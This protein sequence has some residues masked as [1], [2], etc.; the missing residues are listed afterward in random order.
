MTTTNLRT[1]SM[2]LAGTMAY[3]AAASAG[4][5]GGVI[6]FTGG[7]LAPQFDIS[8]GT[9]TASGASTAAR[10]QRID[11]SGRTAYVNLSPEPHDSPSAELSLSVAGR[12]V[13]ADALATRFSD[14]QG[15]TVRPGAGG[16]YHVGALGGTLSMR[17]KD[18]T[19]ALATRVTLTTNYN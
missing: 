5:G 18:E 3:C 7:L 17:T 15:N 4:S 16:T 10:T 2:I 13:A 1:A 6:Y 14:S 11:T 9:P 8:V 19:S 12:A